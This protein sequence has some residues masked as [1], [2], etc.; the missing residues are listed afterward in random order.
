[1]DQVVNPIKD[2]GKNAKSGNK[3][4]ACVK[5]TSLITTIFE[6]ETHLIHKCDIYNL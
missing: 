1:M 3:R 2:D 5:T 4:W 6:H